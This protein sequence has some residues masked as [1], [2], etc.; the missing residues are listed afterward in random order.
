M[1]KLDLDKVIE[2]IFHY[3]YLALNA[4]Q[5]AYLKKKKKICFLFLKWLG[6]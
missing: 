2:Q 3:L 5:N 1:Y 6:L 4:Q